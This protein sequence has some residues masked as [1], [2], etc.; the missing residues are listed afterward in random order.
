MI[1]SKY[2]YMTCWAI[3]LHLNGG[4]NIQFVY[5][6]FIYAAVLAPL[7]FNFIPPVPYN[8]LINQTKSTCMQQSIASLSVLRRCEI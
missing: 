2:A 6:F 1:I 3:R 8:P 4:V 5:V 7:K